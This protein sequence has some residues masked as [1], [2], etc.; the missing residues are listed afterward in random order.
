[1]I[2]K[3]NPNYTITNKIVQALMSIEAAKQVV[4]DLPISHSVLVS[5]RETA[6]L[7]STHYSTQIEGNKLTKKEVS[8]V[9]K[10]QEKLTGRKREEQEV[11]GYY[12]ALDILEK[13]SFSTVEISEK[14]IKHLHSV[15]MS[16]GG[17]KVG[18]TKYRDGQNVIRDGSTGE[19]VYM[20]PEAKDVPDLMK[21]MIEWILSSWNVPAPIVAGIVHYQ[22]VTI[23]PFYDGNGRVARLLATLIL[24][25]RGYGLKG[26]Y[27]LEKYYAKNILAY[28]DALNIGPS[29]NYYI[30]R[31][32][33]DITD[34]IEYFCSGA[35]FAFE[36]VRQNA[37]KNMATRSAD[38][39]SLLMELDNKQRIALDLFKDSTLVT[40]KNVG[41]L[42]GFK[43]RTSSELCRKWTESGFLEIVDSS[44]K[45]R[46]YK[47]VE[48]FLQLLE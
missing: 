13:Y 22:F 41:Q 39:S 2:R 36:K 4:S 46:T 26:I 47:L 29:H 30:G 38:Q 42:F 33:A 31:A 35:S 34:W 7:L 1:M 37:I 28:Y 16:A 10:H 11:K 40:A 24:H 5:L 15:V 12:S 27:C 45:G 3:F 32:D 19:I 48:K 21:N 8:D 43:P 9:V 44:K 20:P 17:K 14:I 23:H 6:K 25:Q 18:Q